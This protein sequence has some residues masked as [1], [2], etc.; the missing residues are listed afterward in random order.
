[1]FDRRYAISLAGL[2][3]YLP[4]PRKGL[5]IRDS[6]CGAPRMRS[7]GTSLDELLAAA[8]TPLDLK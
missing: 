1:V 5:S 7:A 4:E 3:S 6:S 2:I 8:E